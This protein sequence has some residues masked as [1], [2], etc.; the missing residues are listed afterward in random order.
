MALLLVY[1]IEREHRGE[2]CYSLI[3]SKVL[4][5]NPD[6]SVFKGYA[7]VI[8]AKAFISKARIAMRHYLV[9]LLFRLFLGEFKVIVLYWHNRFG[10][11]N[12]E[13]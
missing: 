13:W 3:Y 6:N 5:N 10:T 9:S 8:P 12:H 7:S 2:S 11:G 4:D 1:A